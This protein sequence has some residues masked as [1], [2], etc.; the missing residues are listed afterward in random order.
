MS[1][2]SLDAFAALDDEDK[3]RLQRYHNGAK[4][5]GAA[6]NRLMD[7]AQEHGWSEETLTDVLLLLTR[8]P[9]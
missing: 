8:T 5:S 4:F 1:D 7:F 2:H 3:V 6:R 9:T